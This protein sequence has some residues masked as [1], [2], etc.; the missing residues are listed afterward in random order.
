MNGKLWNGSLSWCTLLEHAKTCGN[1][2]I[3]RTT[4]QISACSVNCFYWLGT[5]HSQAALAKG[6]R[7]PLVIA[8]LCKK[9]VENKLKWGFIP[10]LAF[11]FYPFRKRNL[12][13]AKQEFTFRNPQFTTTH[14]H[15]AL[16][17]WILFTLLYLGRIQN[18]LHSAVSGCHSQ[19]QDHIVCQTNRNQDTVPHVACHIYRQ[20][21]RG[22]G[23]IISG[24]QLGD[25]NPQGLQ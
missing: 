25:S 14:L 18:A 21:Q 13:K 24:L 20:S 8:A 22:W 11:P 23:S 12:H 7:L 16:T 4:K 5:T 17:V 2:G 9:R 19:V 15:L 3:F 6:F 1:T 10:L